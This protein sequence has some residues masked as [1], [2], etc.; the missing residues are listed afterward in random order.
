MEEVEALCRTYLLARA[1]GEPPVLPADEMKRV[2]KQFKAYGRRRA[3][4][5]RKAG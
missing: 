3:S 5:A 4:A 2:L 1:V